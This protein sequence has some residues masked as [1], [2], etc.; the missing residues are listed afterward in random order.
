MPARQ[1]LNVVDAADYLGVT[2]RFMR[3]LVEERRITHVKVGH[4]VRFPTEVLDEFLRQGTRPAVH[5][6]SA[7][8]REEFAQ[9]GTAPV[10]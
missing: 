8:D 5:G 10:R 7:L 3:R 1:M 6:A 4:F 2:T 9:R